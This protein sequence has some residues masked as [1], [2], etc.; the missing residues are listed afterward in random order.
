VPDPDSPPPALVDDDV[1]VD[2]R[3]LGVL[4]LG[5]LEEQPPAEVEPVDP[6][7]V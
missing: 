3:A 2:A 1:E 4:E 6:V 5:W 7:V